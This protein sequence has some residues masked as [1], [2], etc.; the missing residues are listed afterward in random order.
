M[1]QLRQ[2][3]KPAFSV[4]WLVLIALTAASILA[5]PA[6]SQSTEPVGKDS[7]QVG[8]A[9]VTP[10]STVTDGL[11]VF[12]TFGER[13][14]AETTQ[15]GVLPSPMTTRAVLFVNASGRLSRD[16]GV[17]IANPDPANAAHI[18]LNLRQDDGTVLAT[19]KF[20]VLGGRQTAK[21]VT[22]LFE[23]ERAVPKDITGTL[24]IT[25]NIP[26]AVVGLRFR[27]MNFSTLPVRDLSGPNP[28]PKNGNAGGA[29]AA[30]LAQF[31]A[32]GGWSTE[33]IIANTGTAEMVVRVDLFTNEGLPLTT[34]LNGVT[35]STFLNIKVPKD[36]VVVLAPRD[37]KGD[38]EF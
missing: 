30:I 25:S 19:V 17:A 4:L 31:A 24:E 12:E 35:G 14:G 3:I 29:G 33:I 5:A 15:A 20:D 27:G 13:R 11:V 36:G 34:T 37:A 1:L 10:T 8:Y 26:V 21:F 16:L 32:G 9:I 23:N 38:S 2:S 22:Q 28:V 7:M 6:V 18:T